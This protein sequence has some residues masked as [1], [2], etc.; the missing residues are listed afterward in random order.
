M[1]NAWFCFSMLYTPYCLGFECCHKCCLVMCSPIRCS[2]HWARREK[3]LLHSANLTTHLHFVC[4]LRW[5]PVTVILIY[6]TAV[7]VILLNI[8]IAQMSSTYS[9]AKKTARLQYDVDRMLIITRLEHSR[10]HRFVSKFLSTK[11]RERCG[12][13]LFYGTCRWTGCGFWPF[14]PKQGI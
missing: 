2:N 5:L 13:V 10:F 8:L 9:I 6:M 12:G 14:C 4:F 3:P 1:Y 11:G 7:V